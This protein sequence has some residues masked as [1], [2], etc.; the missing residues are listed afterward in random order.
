MGLPRTKRVL[1]EAMRLRSAPI[2]KKVGGKM[3]TVG[4]KKV[5]WN[6]TP[7]KHESSAKTLRRMRGKKIS[8]KRMPP[9][10]K[11]FLNMKRTQV[12]RSI[13]KNMKEWSMIAENVL[14]FV[15]IHFNGPDIGQVGVLR[16]DGEIVS[17][18]V[19]TVALRNEA[20]VLK[21][22]WKTMNTDVVVKRNESK[23][24]HENDE[25]VKAVSELRKLNA[26][27]DSKG[28]ETAMEN[29]AT[30]FP[31]VVYLTEGELA[32][33]VKAALVWTVGGLT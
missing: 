14:G 18:K 15:D 25:F 16:K 28:L 31:G 23:R 22:D 13:G 7:K 6:D 8:Q 2:R 32:G 20:R 29:T 21:F 33:R 27:S 9:G 10:L 17:V 1:S 19:P 26:L 5:K 11:K 4:Y 24:I 12:N 30:K 3:K